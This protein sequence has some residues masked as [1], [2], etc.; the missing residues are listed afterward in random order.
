M[1]QTKTRPR[2]RRSTTNGH[3]TSATRAKKTRVD[4]VRKDLRKAGRRVVK[5]YEETWDTVADYQDKVA[6][7]SRVDWLADLARA[8]ARIMRKVSSAYG[9]EARKLIS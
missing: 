2:T 6:D 9:T 7:K 4:E 3:R 1:T 5:L 8:Q